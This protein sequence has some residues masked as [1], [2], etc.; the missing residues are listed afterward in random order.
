MEST[1]QELQLANN[2]VRTT[3]HHIFLTGKAGTGKTTFLRG[4]KQ[5]PPKR[6]V[7]TAPTGV[8]AIN[9]GG[10]TLHSFFQIP[11]SAFVPNSEAYNKAETIWFNKRKLDIMTNMELLVIDEISMVRCD[12]LDAVDVIL[13]RIRK[14]SNIPFGGVQLLMIGDLYQLA[15]VSSQA[16]WNILRMY[17]DT[18][19]FFSCMALRN[20]EVISIELK[21]IYR[22]SDSQFIELLNQVRENRL[23]RV[24]YEHL[25]TRYI[26]EFIPPATEHYI[27]LTTHNSS[28]DRINALR[29]ERL[30]E[31]TYYFNAAIEGEYPQSLYP[32]AATLQLKEG[33]QV[34]FIRNDTANERRYFNGKIGTIVSL[35][36]EQI[37]VQCGDIPDAIDVQ[38]IT[39]EN[40]EYT[41]DNNTKQITEKI[42]GTFTQYPLRLAW[43][44]TIHKSQGLTFEHAII[45]ANAAF[46]PGQVYVA[47]S[48]CKSFEGLVLSSPLATNL[49]HTDP[50]ITQ[51]MGYI[52]HNPPDQKRLDQAQIIYQQRLL[53]ECWDFQALW[54]NLKKLFNLLRSRQIELTNQTTNKANNKI[55]NNEIPNNEILNN[56]ILNNEI[57]N[58]E[59]PNNEIPNNEIPNKVTNIE[60]LNTIEQNAITDILEVSEYF[61]RQLQNLYKQDTLPETDAYLQERIRKASNYFR[62]KLEQRIISWLRELKFGT[63]NVQLRQKLKQ[64]LVDLQNNIAIKLA[65]I[66]SCRERFS[67]PSYL[68]AIATASIDYKSQIPIPGEKDM[69]KIDPKD[70]FGL[71]H[72]W[73][74]KIA[75]QEEQEGDNRY[76]IFTRSLLRQI[77]ARLPQTPEALESINGIG[78]TTV[79]RYG[80]EILQII[81]KYCKTY[82][83][84]PKQ[85]Q[86]TSKPKE[87]TR[88]ISYQLYKQGKNIPEI[89]E[90]RGLKPTT[91]EGHL[92]H[93][94]ALGKLSLSDF[95]S[96]EKQEKIIEIFSEEGIDSSLTIVKNR[97]G[98]DYSY[99]ELRMVQAYLKQR[100]IV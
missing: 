14:S 73:R 47:L 27:T 22:Q 91:I 48:R 58:N 30:A 16:E 90:Q 12:L 74:S 65:C 20:L 79:K 45:D 6:M 54:I 98:D 52:T 7:I 17:Y 19:Y 93:Y 42:I 62:A 37:R 76:K 38:P 36:K 13:R 44:I 33:A 55:P 71:L 61:K 3:N 56:E 86:T 68:N 99:G 23:D 70:L 80:A 87:D 46:S 67:T 40:I 29:L 59:I 84:K 72:Q 64:V 78:K 5:N 2:F 75:Q 21:H 92:S 57:P 95:M 8:A 60:Y 96:T 43:A 51:F 39:W 4:L 26:P 85:V 1:N 89:A 41:I 35:N 50:T 9:A 25:N 11:L 100:K 77:V 49:I 63:D 15:P 32:T 66:D 10:V 94:I 81:N 97:L 82:S 24:N 18:N 83:I 88:L 31:S 53:Q 28:A 69:A 34:M